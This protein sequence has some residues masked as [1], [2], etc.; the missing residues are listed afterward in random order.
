MELER[1]PLLGSSSRDD[2]VA[3]LR[4]LAATRGVTPE[5][6]DRA[7]AE[8]RVDMLLVDRLLTRG[9]APRTGEELSEGSGIPLE[10]AGRLWRA[11][12]F[13]LSGEEAVFT[14]Q[15]EEALRTIKGLVDLGLSSP[16][17]AVQVTR[18][19]GQSMARVADALVASADAAAKGQGRPGWATEPGDEGL[20][21][22][23]AI[24]I[25]SEIVFPSMEKLLVYAWRRH[26]QAA[27][28]RRAS[29]RRDGSG[30]LPVTPE[31]TVGFADMVGFTA[32]SSQLDADALARVVDRFDDL[33]HTTV[34]N[35]GGRPVKMIGDEVMFVVPRP[36]DAVRI[37][38]DLVD[39]YA[40]DDVL[41]DVRVGIATG[42]VLAREGD[43][44][45]SVV[46]RAH[47]I[48]SIADAGTVLTGDEVHAE[49]E[50]DPGGWPDDL[51]WA[52]LKPREL[53]DIG[54]VRLWQVGRAGETA[55]QERRSGQRWRRLSDLSAE[56]AA[57]RAR[58]ERAVATARAAGATGAP[59]GRRAQAARMRPQGS[60]S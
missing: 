42:P 27:A 53:K 29:M 43:F 18:V 16:E 24:A 55:S 51:V 52:P 25:G 15:D 3:G 23:E 44:F 31:M 12:G 6:F 48:V 26:I 38:L 58:G 60:G 19:L 41:S 47:R 20:L 9:E 14:D 4:A 13:P 46:N 33:A 32:L 11:L 59:T 22:A 54:R 57:A 39:A 36:L 45:G 37:G 35:G 1:T 49:V 17:T 28:R 34:V 10:E 8:D 5:E 7:L 30:V 40:D 2:I 56:L 21:L 50:A